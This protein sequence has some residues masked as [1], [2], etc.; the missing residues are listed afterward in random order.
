MTEPPAPVPFEPAHLLSKYDPG[1]VLGE[2]LR[3]LQQESRRLNLVSRETS[4]SDLER[5]AAES[6]LPLEHIGPP[7]F[8]RYLDIGSGGGF[9]GIPTVVGA[10]IREAILMERTLKKSLALKRIATALGYEPPRL[11]VVHSDF[12]QH[13]F[14]SGFSLITLRLVKL[15]RRLL[16]KVVKCLDDDGTFVYFSE[17]PP[18]IETTHLC[19]K[20]HRYISG[21][22]STPKA[23]TILRKK[24]QVF[25]D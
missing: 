14:S 24:P 15:S 13:K 11:D 8:E 21:M 12:E 22:S 10:Q 9:P 25:V 1:G 2:Y 6:L 23:F 18:E 4:F 16:K 19:L 20:T 17:P 7:M 3:L 5:L